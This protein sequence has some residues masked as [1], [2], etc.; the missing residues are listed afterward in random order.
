MQGA[1]GT[2]TTPGSRG[3]PA[4]GSQ[5]RPGAHLLPAAGSRG[6]PAS[7][8][9][10]FHAYSCHA[11]QTSPL[12][13]L[14]TPPMPECPSLFPNPASFPRSRSCTSRRGSRLCYNTTLER[15]AQKEIKGPSGKGK[16]R[17][18]GKVL[19]PIHE[20]LVVAVCVGELHEILVSSLHLSSGGLT[21]QGSSSSSSPL[22]SSSSSSPSPSPS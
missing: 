17:R 7:E 5:A 21:T 12:L 8:S 1:R 13:K 20:E 14:C 9:I 10:R 15:R 2:H 3:I 6:T 16:R 22:P 11:V 4:V 19:E 18:K